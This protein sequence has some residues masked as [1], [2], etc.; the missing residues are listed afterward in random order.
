MEEQKFQE[1][2]KVKDNN[3]QTENTLACARVLCH[4]EHTHTGISNNYSVSDHARVRAQAREASVHESG[5]RRVEGEDLRRRSRGSAGLL[6]RRKTRF[7]RSAGT[8]TATPSGSGRY[9]T[10]RS[11]KNCPWKARNADITGI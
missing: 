11:T 2:R 7:G 10:S 3:Q 4:T 5:N 8:A 1:R 6:P 9:M